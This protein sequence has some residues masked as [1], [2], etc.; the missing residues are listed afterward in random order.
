MLAALTATI[1]S[2]LERLNPR[3]RVLLGIMAVVAVAM[4]CF[5]VV[6]L[7][8]RSISALEDEVNEQAMLL[9]QLR[10]TAPQL[11][12]RL[13]VDEHA[14]AGSKVEPPPLGT[15]LQT[16]A[17][18]AGMGETD[19]EMTPQPEEQIGP[20]IRKSVEVRLR[21]KPLGELANLWALTASD[22]AEY[23]V[24]ITKLSIRR[25]RTEEDAYDVEMTVSSFH[26][27]ATT[28]NGDATK[29]GRNNAAS[30]RNKVTP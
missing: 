24:A 13:E 27:S 28:T 29:Q 4:V 20:W 21:R 26:R 3:E 15:Q 9:E 22:R 16:H 5:L 17:T 12:E 23:P 11:R 19:L 8:N 10:E 2:A 18:T 30:K 14:P 7:V 6:L 25:R 1:S